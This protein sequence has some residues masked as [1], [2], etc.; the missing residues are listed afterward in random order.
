MFRKNSCSETLES[1]SINFEK[2]NE[3]YIFMKQQFVEFEP[4]Y[5]I[6]FNFKEWHIAICPNGG[7]I[8]ACKKKAIYDATRGSKINKNI[9]VTYQNLRTKYYIPIDWDYDKTWVVCLDFNEKE[10]LYAICNDG[11]IFKIDITTQKALEKPSSQ[12]FENEP[13]VK[14]KLFE[15]GF[16]ALTLNGDFYYVPDIKKPSPQLFFAMKSLLEFSN[17][18]DFLLIVLFLITILIPLT[19]LLLL[20]NFLAISD[21]PL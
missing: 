16:I 17:D 11:R 9:I 20:T 8:A 15:K 18:V 4:D 13:I 14:A 12:L 1:I 3:D 10:Q 7:L 19:I 6:K 2:M 5:K 21:V